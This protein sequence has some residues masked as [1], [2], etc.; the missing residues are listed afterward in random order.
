[1]VK[2]S[3]LTVLDS[4][5]EKLPDLLVEKDQWQS[6]LID[7]EH[8]HVERI[9]RQVE[10]NRLY[11]H[12]IHKCDP[13]LAFPHTHSWPSAMLIVAGQYDMKVGYEAST[14]LFAP[15]GTKGASFT[16]VKMHCP[17]GFRYEMT[18]PDSWHSVCPTTE[19][20]WTIMVTGKPWSKP[21]PKPTKQLNSLAPEREKEIV[22]QFLD[23]WERWT[24]QTSVCGNTT[25]T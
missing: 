15:P 10:E 24:K 8:P 2:T 11:L 6:L 17:P 14:S 23:W 3:M 25:L 9:W 18:D 12:V 21:G 1:M 5:L 13:G 19:T 7:Y 20:V 22:L 4:V 16:S